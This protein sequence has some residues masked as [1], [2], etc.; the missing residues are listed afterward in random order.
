M[1]NNFNAQHYASLYC[2]YDPES[3]NRNWKQLLID[4]VVE[5]IDLLIA[6]NARDC[7]TKRGRSSKNHLLWFTFGSTINGR[8]SG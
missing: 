4:N 6:K 5:T 2:Q 3:G 7:S 8:K 1:L